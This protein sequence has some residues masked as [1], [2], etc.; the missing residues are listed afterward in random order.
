MFL[1]WFLWYS[2]ASVD[3]TQQF[4]G[5]EL[6]ILSILEFELYILHTYWKVCFF[7]NSAFESLPVLNIL[8]WMNVKRSG[9]N[10]IV[11]CLIIQP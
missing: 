8:C 1:N 5:G 7:I 2:I 10:G 11:V 3:K 9:F 4:R 6:G